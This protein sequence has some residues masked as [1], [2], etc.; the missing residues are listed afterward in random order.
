MSRHSS[1]YNDMTRVLC[2]IG[3]IVAL[4]TIIIREF[5][6]FEKS[7]LRDHAERRVDLGRRRQALKH[8]QGQ[9]EQ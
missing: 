9:K 8:R 2:I 3:I 6:K 4:A 5:T 1:R 7:V